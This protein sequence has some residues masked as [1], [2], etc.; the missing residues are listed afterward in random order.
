MWEILGLG[1]GGDGNWGERSDSG[2]VSQLNWHDVL[3]NHVGEWG[4]HR[5]TKGCS[6]AGT[7]ATRRMVVLFTDT[8]G[9]GGE[10]GNQR[11]CL[12]H[13]GHWMSKSERYKLGSKQDIEGT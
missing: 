1:E 2:H 12:G 7:W 5:E 13:A 8:G 3:M 10:W 9:R 6:C 11:F 4:Q